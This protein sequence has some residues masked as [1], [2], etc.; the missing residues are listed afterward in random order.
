MD[1]TSIL[2]IRGVLAVGVGLLAMLWPALTL[3][4][5][6]GLFGAYAFFDG[7]TNLALGLRRTD[8]RERS[9]F[10]VFQ[11]IAGI[12]AGVLT[13]VWPGV[14]ALVLLA[15]IAV[16]AIVTGALE[17]AAAIRLR[18][19][20]EGEWRLALGGSLSIIF[21]AVLVASPALGALGLAWALGAY[22]AA[23][24]ILL[25]VLAIRLRTATPVR[26]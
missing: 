13:F 12:A 5:L 4:F 25:V 22:A 3:A 10:R 19:E 8:G 2:L 9:W 11:G 18:H 24:G 14:T 20:I 23:M 26:A 16:W 6:V 17:I 15:W 21:G 1:R 7:I